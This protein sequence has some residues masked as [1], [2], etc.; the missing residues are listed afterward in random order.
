MDNGRNH[1]RKGME[2]WEGGGVISGVPDVWRV[3]ACEGHSRVQEAPAP[4]FSQTKTPD[5][6][7]VKHL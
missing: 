7:P 3:E 1:R 2:S 4:Y 5:P 6:T